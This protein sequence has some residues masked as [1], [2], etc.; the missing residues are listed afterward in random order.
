M[1]LV[2]DGQIVEYKDEGKGKVV[3]MLHGW[4]SNSDTFRQLATDLSK[5]FRVIRFDFPGFGQSPRPST[6]WS[7]HDYANFAKEF[8]KKLRISDLYAVI[9]HSFGGRVIIKGVSQKLIDPQ[10]VVLMGSAGVKPKKRFKIRAYKAIAKTGKA[11]T[12]LPGLNK[13]QSRLRKNL[14]Q[15]IGNMDYYQS[16]QMRNIFV[17]TINEDLLPEVSNIKQPTLLIW[18]END[19]EAPLSDAKLMAN[20]LPDHEMDV[21]TG[22]GHFVFVDNYQKVIDDLE[23]FL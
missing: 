4:G 1:K 5:R 16:G 17:K 23:R 22:A 11:I 2:I 15:S 20:R 19:T 14:Y 6:D 18:G 8:L 10:K 12:S 21:I 3:L 13:L 7:I 9:G